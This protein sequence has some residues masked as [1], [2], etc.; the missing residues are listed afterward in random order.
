MRWGEL[1][2]ATR[3]LRALQLQIYIDVSL[4]A[5]QR[6]GAHSASAVTAAGAPPVPPCRGVEESVPRGR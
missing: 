3:R 6:E 5:R 4:A 1:E 2:R